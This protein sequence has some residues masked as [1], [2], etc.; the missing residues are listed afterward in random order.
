MRTLVALALILIAGTAWAEAP[1]RI[2]YD[3]GSSGI[4]I[5][6]STGD[7]AGKASIDYLADVW[8]DNVIDR[9]NEQTVAALANL[10]QGR[11]CPAVAGAYSAWRLAADKGGPDK[12]AETLR[13]LNARSGVAIFVIPQAVEGGYGYFAASQALGARLATPFILDIGGGSLQFAAS[14]AGWGAALGQKA[15]R[16]QVC[17]EL[18]HGAPTDC[19]P[20]P[21]GADAS[22][23]AEALLAPLVAQA[24]QA[25][26]GGFAVTAISAPVVHGIH[27]I[28]Q[29]LARTRP[30]FPGQVDEHGFDLAALDAALA[31]LSVR[32]DEAI[33]AL[34]HGCAAC[35][36]QFIRTDVTDMLLLHSFM[37]GLDIARLE[38]AEAD[39]TNV[40]GILAD[41]KA[42]AWAGHYACY[43]SR[44]AVQGVGAYDG[45]PGTCGD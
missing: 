42:A 35:K 43:L 38:V 16:K 11:H 29:H 30:G 25:L 4:R 44:L 26:G 28:L 17:A 1:C 15:W 7:L 14:Q 34:L 8:D 5:G 3:I 19:P 36:P 20:N 9:T 37:A 41:A 24:R 6:A 21:V 32:D 33:H 27:P 45:D 13:Q 12:V 2:G 22:A 23:R 31:L 10:A 39:I 40:P 18:K